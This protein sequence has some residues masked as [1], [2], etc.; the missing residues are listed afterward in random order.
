M[1]TA[2]TISRGRTTPRSPGSSVQTWRAMLEVHAEIIGRL[3]TEFRGR[4]DL[5]VSEF[6]VLI[7]IGP[8]EHLR[9]GDLAERVILT[10]TALTRLIDRLVARDLLIRATSPADHRAV[11]ISLT[12]DGRQVRRAAARTNASVVRAPFAALTP[13][14]LRLLDDTIHTLR[15]AARPH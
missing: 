2:T 5:S 11:L 3:E 1:S 6:D 9:H 8:H 12:D 15:D 4:H 14:Q 7:N 10:R 13:Q